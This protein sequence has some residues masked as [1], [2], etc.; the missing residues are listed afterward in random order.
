MNPPKWH[1]DTRGD[2]WASQAACQ[3]MDTNIWFPEK[4]SCGTAAIRIC[5][6][7]PVQVE[8]LEAAIT[9]SDLAHG[10]RGGLTPRQR[11]ELATG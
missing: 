3:G 8:C 2:H 4:G 1:S 7:C 6:T 11:R 10:V 5:R 9:D